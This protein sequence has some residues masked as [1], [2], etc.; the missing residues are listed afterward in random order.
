MNINISYEWSQLEFCTCMK[1]S[2]FCWI[3]GSALLVCSCTL[4]RFACYVLFSPNTIRK[5]F[6][7]CSLKILCI[8]SDTFGMTSY[9]EHKTWEGRCEELTIFATKNIV[10][11]SNNS[12]WIWSLLCA[13]HQTFKYVQLHFVNRHNLNKWDWNIH[14]NIIMF[15]YVSYLKLFYINPHYSVLDCTGLLLQVN[16]TKWDLMKKQNKK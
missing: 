13:P 7:G 14:V 16:V 2:I 11:V 5:Y 12:S 9:N 10:I 8:V 15:T 1:L 6:T 3:F 4:S